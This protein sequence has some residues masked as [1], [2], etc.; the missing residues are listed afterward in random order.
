MTH[1]ELQYNSLYSPCN[2]VT[3][4]TVYATITLLALRNTEH[5]NNI[6]G[7]V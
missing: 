4:L 6:M 1:N 3:D 5:R 7:G 2:T